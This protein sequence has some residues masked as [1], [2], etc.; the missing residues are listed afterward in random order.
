MLHKL[1][2]G[3]LAIALMCCMAT[4]SY[5]RP[6]TTNARNELS[7][8]VTCHLNIHRNIRN[9]PIDFIKNPMPT[10]SLASL[11]ASYLDLRFKNNKVVKTIEKED[12]ENRF[13]KLDDFKKY[14]GTIYGYQG[15]PAKDSSITIENGHIVIPKYHEFD[16]EESDGVD[17]YEC[18]RAE[19][20]DYGIIRATF[21]LE[22]DHDVA[23]YEVYSGTF[24]RNPDNSFRILNIEVV[25]ALVE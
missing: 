22:Q 17:T 3:S 16:Y 18:L 14:A 2:I 25:T 23:N 8:L 6:L 5:T 21:I 12:G 13:I 1:L 24:L 9:Y 20:N 10:L 4:A 11:M 7:Q 15:N 19:E